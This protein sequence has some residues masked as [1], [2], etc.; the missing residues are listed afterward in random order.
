MTTVHT[1]SKMMALLALGQSVWLD[2]LRRDM[3]QSGDL[4]ARVADGLRGMTSNPSIFE[5][6]IGGSKDYDAAL[7]GPAMRGKSDMDAFEAIAVEDVRMAA[8]VFRTVYDSTDGAD[9]FVS[10]EVSPRLARDTQG[11]LDEARRLWREVGR[12]NVMIKIPGTREGWPAIEQALEEGININIT[13]LFSVEHHKAVAEA[14]LNAMEARIA[15]GKPVNR[16]A[17]VASF[18]VSRVDS[19]VDKRLEKIGSPAAAGL[20]GQAA[21]ANAKLAYEL[22]SE[23]FSGP[24]WTKIRDAGARVQRPLWA[25]TSTKNPRYGDVR[26]IE[27]LIG[28]ETINTVPPETLQLFEEHG[29][30]RRTLVPNADDARALLKQVAEAGVDFDDVTQTLEDEGIEKFEASYRK[31]LGV[32]SGKRQALGVAARA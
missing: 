18:F 17:S 6:A 22:F 21:I 14:Y 24:R 15:A 23:L 4:A 9:G 26:Y 31:L 16:V 12:P 3:I 11:S 13:L 20:L 2:Y 30:V 27:G 1:T 19:E 7:T 10:I 28:P 29:V 25:S 5:S 8:D 32:I